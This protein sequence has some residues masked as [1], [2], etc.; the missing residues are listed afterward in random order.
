VMHQ[1][2]WKDYGQPSR[3]RGLTAPI[4]ARCATGIIKTASGRA[5]RQYLLS[6]ITKKA[7]RC[8]RSG[9]SSCSSS[10][11]VISLHSS[12]IECLA[13]QEHRRS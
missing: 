3:L 7:R 10:E 8:Q 12:E 13:L 6:R 2:Y 5:V 4:A 1:I 9:H 11:I